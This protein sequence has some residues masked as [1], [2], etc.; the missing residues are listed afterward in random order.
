[1]VSDYEN[2]SDSD[3]DGATS[4]TSSS[5][6]DS[7]DISSSSSSSREIRDTKNANI[8]EDDDDAIMFA[9]SMSGIS[10][11]IV[12]VSENIF[13]MAANLANNSTP[14]RYSKKTRYSAISRVQISSRIGG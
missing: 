13:G 1:M 8:D 4:S 10:D 6:R 9:D 14:L 5:S 12:L 11:Q 3:E 2:Y 7:R